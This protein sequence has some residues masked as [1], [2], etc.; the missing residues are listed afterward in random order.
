[1]FYIENRLTSAWFS[2]P[3]ALGMALLAS[4]CVKSFGA[5]FEAHLCFLETSAHA[6]L[7]HNKCE[8]EVKE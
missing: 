7:T 5:I 6:Q 2:L 8:C 3:A 1:M 4:V